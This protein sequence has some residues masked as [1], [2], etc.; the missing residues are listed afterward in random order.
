MEYKPKCQILQPMNPITSIKEVWTFDEKTGKSYL[1]PNFFH[2]N[3]VIFDTINMEIN[4]SAS[5]PLILSKNP[6]SSHYD[7]Y[8][9][10]L[11]PNASDG[12]VIVFD[13]V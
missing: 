2:E 1:L 8:A 9:Q 11:V 13:G 4:Y 12:R 7:K 10:V 3:V 5:S 6:S